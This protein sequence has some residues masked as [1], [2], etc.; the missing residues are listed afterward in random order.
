MP[1]RT[2]LAM[3]VMLLLGSVA[4]A[5]MMYEW[6]DDNGAVTLRDTPPPTAK[7]RKLKTYSHS[8]LISAPTPPSASSK[9]KGTTVKALQPLPKKEPFSGT[10]EL[11]VTSWCG[12]SKRALDY[13]KEKQIPYVAYDIEK[14]SAAKQRHKELGGGGVPLIVI[15]SHR[16]RGFSPETLEKYLNN[17]SE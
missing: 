7:A 2:L 8:T 6:V 11:Y 9:H 16:M 12:H 5:D 4:A 13:L 10:V 1:I 3:V 17:S 15:G 14:D